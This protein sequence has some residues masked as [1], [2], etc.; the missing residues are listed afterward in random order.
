MSTKAR[1]II[2]SATEV[3]AA[4]D[5]PAFEFQRAIS[6]PPPLKYWPEGVLPGNQN[7]EPKWFSFIVPTIYGSNTHVFY[8]P[9]FTPG[10]MLWVK[11]TWAKVYEDWPPEMDNSPH[12]IEYKADTGAKYPGEWPDDKGDDDACGR[13]RSPVIMPRSASRLTIE[14]TDVRWDGKKLEWVFEAKRIEP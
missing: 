4:L 7:Q 8:Q 6:D 14:I 10:D 5:N 9:K 13:W 11:E 12:Y 2:L 3:R 1:S